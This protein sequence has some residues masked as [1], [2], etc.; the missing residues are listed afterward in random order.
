M[1]TGYLPTGSISTPAP[2]FT[3]DS[4][5]VVPEPVKSS[6]DPGASRISSEVSGMGS[7]IPGARKS[8]R[9]AA[10]LHRGSF[11]QNQA[12]DLRTGKALRIYK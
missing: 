11:P 12:K 10:W 3:R 4:V 8:T 2:G 7:L 1:S 6:V 9:P 5:V